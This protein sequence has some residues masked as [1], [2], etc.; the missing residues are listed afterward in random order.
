AAHHR[1]VVHRDIKAGNI[2]VDDAGRAVILDFGLAQMGGESRIT[3][4]G[5]TVGTAAYMSP[6]Q[7]QG[8]P[9]DQP[10]DLRPLG[11]LLYEMVA[12]RLPFRGEYELAVM[13]NIVNETPEPIETVRHEATPALARIL[14]RALQKK[15]PDRYQSAKQLAID[16]RALRG[17]YSSPDYS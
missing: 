5:A 7:A 1:G 13:Y 2:I 14:D 8:N 3:R 17:R 16:L 4:T 9:M 6:E 15:I 10:T 12:G 11:V